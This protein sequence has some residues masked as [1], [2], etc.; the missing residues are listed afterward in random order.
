MWRGQSILAVVVWVL[1]VLV[2]DDVDVSKHGRAH[3][4]SR[5]ELSAATDGDDLDPLAV[6]AIDTCS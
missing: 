2:L 3:E 4:R 1:L 5:R 6:L